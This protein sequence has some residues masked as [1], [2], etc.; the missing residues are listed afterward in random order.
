MKKIIPIMGFLGMVL[1]PGSLFAIGT[2]AEGSILAKVIQFES[3]GILFTSYEGI[4]EITG[5]NKEEVCEEEKDECYTPVKEQINFSVRSDNAEVVNFLN[6]NINQEVILGYVVHRIKSLVLSSEM[7]VLSAGKQESGIPEG[8]GDRLIVK[9]TGT[10]RNFSVSGKVVQLDYQGTFIGTY[11][12]FYL[13]EVRGKVHPFS[14]TDESMAKHALKTM[15][16]STKYN[17]GIS[18]AFVKGFRKSNYDL[19]EINYKEPAGGVYTSSNT[20]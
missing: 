10:K 11:E 18:V 17:L 8:V 4:L 19:F 5:V 6:K 13:D 12:G 16:G 3:R 2:Y 20:P 9:K 15:K 14:V 1:N 7:E